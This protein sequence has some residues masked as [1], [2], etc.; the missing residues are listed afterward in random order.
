MYMTLLGF[1]ISNGTMFD[2]V[3]MCGMM[4]LL[5]SDMVYMLV[6]CVSP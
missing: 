4:M 1:G 5:F 2:S 6:R 3:H